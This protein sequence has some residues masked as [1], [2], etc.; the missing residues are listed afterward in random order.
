VLAGQPLSVEVR[1]LFDRPAE[2]V[3]LRYRNGGPWTV[4]ALAFGGGERWSGLIP[5][6]DV[7]AGQPLEYTFEAQADGRVWTAPEVDAAVVPFRQI[8]G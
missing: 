1:V 6:E 3:T 2:L 4:V 5:G 8:P 7:I